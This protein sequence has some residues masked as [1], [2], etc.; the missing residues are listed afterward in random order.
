MQIGRAERAGC[1][2]VYLPARGLFRGD[3]IA[4]L[5][6]ESRGGRDPA[7]WSCTKA[8]VRDGLDDGVALISRLS[9]LKLV[10]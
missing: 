7:P 10:P 3:C 1:D 6:G 8:T 5:D 4:L 2:A 9:A